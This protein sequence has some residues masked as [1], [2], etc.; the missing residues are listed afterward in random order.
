MET[1]SELV[2]DVLNTE[3]Q[4]AMT[5]IVNKARVYKQ[6]CSRL[7]EIIAQSRPN[8]KR[9]LGTS[10]TSP[11]KLRAPPLEWK[12]VASALTSQATS[13]ASSSS[14]HQAAIDLQKALGLS[15]EQATALAQRA[16]SYSKTKLRQLI[17][18]F[19][20]GSLPVPQ[21]PGRRLTAGQQARFSKQQSN[22][23]ENAVTQ[24]RHNDKVS[25]LSL[26]AAPTSRNICG[27]ET[28]AIECPPL[29]ILKALWFPG[30]AAGSEESLL[31]TFMEVCHLRVVSS[32]TAAAAKVEMQSRLKQ[33]KYSPGIL[34]S[35]PRKLRS[36]RL[37]SCS[38]ASQHN[39][40]VQ[41]LTHPSHIQVF[42]ELDLYE[43]PIPALEC[44]ILRS[45]LCQMIRLKHVVLPVNGWSEPGPRRQFLR[46]LPAA[47]SNNI[48]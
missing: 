43:A 46:A 10:Q 48:E 27:S 23:L 25:L 37:L 14:S 12:Q 34:A 6:L 4:R 9:A 30:F 18:V 1:S 35:L 28:L 38:V 11:V 29:P 2:Q 32:N 8:V 20:T 16:Q 26:P 45:S 17:G 22:A 44:A 24:A 15:D 40:L 21:P 42:E 36:G 33:F 3:R 19:Y 31:L 7:L 39:R 5:E 41:F 47:V 13:I